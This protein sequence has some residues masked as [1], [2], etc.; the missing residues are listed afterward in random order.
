MKI[1]EIDDNARLKI[2]YGINFAGNRVRSTYGPAGLNVGIGSKFLPPV[3]SNDGL[4]T[5]KSIELEDEVENWAVRVMEGG[6]QAVNDLV[7]GARTATAILIQ[8]IFN[9]G[10][11]RF[12]ISE[13]LIKKVVNPQTIKKEIEEACVLAIEE[14]KKR[15]IE[16][17]TLEDIQKVAFISVENKKIG[18]IIAEVV[19]KVGKDGKIKVEE[20]DELGINPNISEGM[21]I[22][23]GMICRE[24]ATKELESIIEN[25]FIL[26]VKEKVMSYGMFSNLATQLE[27]RKIKDLVIFAPDFDKTVITTFKNDRAREIFRVL[28]IKIP[29]WDNGLFQDICTISG[30]TLI[31]ENELIDF[32]SC[33]QIEKIISSLEK[34]VLVGGIQDKEDALDLLKAELKTVKSPFERQ[35]L[36][37]RIGR[38]TGKIAIIEVGAITPIDRAR[39]KDKVEDGVHDTQGALQ[40]GVIEG[41]GKGLQK[42]VLNLPPSILSEPLQEPF[43]QIQKSGELEIGADVIDSVKSLRVAIESACNIAGNL[44]TIGTVS[45]EKNESDTE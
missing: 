42:I 14:L 18:D 29:P 2:K 10:Y 28:A 39:L 1:I 38:I 4:R 9:E 25:P 36:E 45:V 35:K 15:H 8:E 31:Q 41:G 32:N 33:G 43:R 23:H 37:D 16:I 20:S 26:V 34:T 12:D 30:A 6:M 19:F 40:E 7:G 17:S 3:I 21:E 13:S 22:T 27:E 5:I 11:K 44:L 24:M